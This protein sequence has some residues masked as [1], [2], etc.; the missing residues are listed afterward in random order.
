MTVHE[1][2][3][4]D[5]NLSLIEERLLIFDDFDSHVLLVPM[6][7]CLYHLQYNMKNN[8]IIKRAWLFCTVKSHSIYVS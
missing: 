8:Q 5:L 7:I 4:L 6:V 1:F 2:K 3:Q